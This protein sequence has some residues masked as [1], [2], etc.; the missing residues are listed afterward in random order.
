MYRYMDVQ[1]STMNRHNDEN[2]LIAI[3]D[4][5]GEDSI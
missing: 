3:F 4:S 2:N 1:F 5:F